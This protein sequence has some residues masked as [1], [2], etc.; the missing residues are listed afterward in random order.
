MD[1][2]MSMSVSSQYPPSQAPAAIGLPS[3]AP[4]PPQVFGVIIPGSSPRT[5]FS[6][7]PSGTKYTLAL[8]DHDLPP[9][10]GPAAVTDLVF[11]FLPGA[12]QALPPGS[13]AM[14][15]WQATAAI[16]GTPNATTT[17]FELLGAITPGKPSGILRTGWSTNEALAGLIS[18]NNPNA[19]I[20][21][22]LGV[23]VEPL[24]NVQNLGA[25]TGGGRDDG[26]VAKKIAMD[27]FNYL[28]SFDD[29]GAKAGYMTVPVNVF[30]RW[31]TRFQN[32]LRLDPVFFMKN[33]DS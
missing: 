24:A 5:D 33:R 32:K 23:S 15:Y 22:T 6:P 1:G 31:M 17:G 18:T 11:F 29:T 14:L 30:D 13:G 7:D 9:G 10:G 4:V 2:Q 3:A 19:R 16:A 27:L 12:V 20:T 25:G 26:N 21:V 8:T 28:Q